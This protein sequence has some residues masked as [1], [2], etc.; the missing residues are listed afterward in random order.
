MSPITLPRSVDPP[1]ARER[2]RA[3]LPR[4][5]PA[6]TAPLLTKLA[7]LSASAQPFGREPALHAHTTRATSTQK[8]CPKGPAYVVPDSC[9]CPSSRQRGAGSILPATVEN[10][11]EKS[12]TST[13]NARTPHS[14]RQVPLAHAHVRHLSPHK[15]LLTRTP[16]QNW[17]ARRALPTSASMN[18]STTRRALVLHGATP[19]PG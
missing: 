14:R 10:K 13:R 6:S 8:S 5:L 7:E 2:V 11:R 16:N 1:R 12:T 9:A 19:R 18:I 17:Q 15:R 3:P 4:D